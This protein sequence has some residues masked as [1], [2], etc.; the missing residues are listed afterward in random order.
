MICSRL[1]RRHALC[2]IIAATF[3]S[4]QSPLARARADVPYAID[5]GSSELGVG[6]DPGED[7]LWFTQFPVQAG[8][9][10]INSISVAYGRPGGVSALDGLP[11]KILLYEDP[12]GG[13]PWNSV[14]KTSIDTTVAN[15]NSNTF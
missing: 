14:L 6:I 4:W 9:E 13:L 1:G 12:D 5:D 7:S 10:V 8:G 2:A 11:V 3:V 15:G